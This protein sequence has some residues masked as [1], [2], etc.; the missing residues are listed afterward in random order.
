M[1]EGVFSEAGAYLARILP[2]TVH[3]RVLGEGDVL[4][5]M[6][7]SDIDAK[8]CGADGQQACCKLE[9]RLP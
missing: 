9:G 1:T 8:S 5:P 3:A 2:Y 6:I 4:S 7:D